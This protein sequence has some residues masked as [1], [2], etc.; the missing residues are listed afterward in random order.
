MF[1]KKLQVKHCKH[2][3]LTNDGMFSLEQLSPGAGFWK[4]GADNAL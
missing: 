4:Q 1:I 3:V 2:T